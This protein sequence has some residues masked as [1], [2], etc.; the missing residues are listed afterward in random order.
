MHPKRD[1]QYGVFTYQ[2]LK[3]STRS[4]RSF[5]A[6]QIHQDQI[7]PGQFHHVTGHPWHPL[8]YRSLENNK[9]VPWKGEITIFSIS[10]WKFTLEIRL[11]SNRAGS[12]LSVEI[13]ELV[14]PCPWG[15]H[16]IVRV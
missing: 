7:Q 10:D 11:A 12:P 15:V 16:P 14:N 2:G 6:V 4:R 3:E 5:T 13:E 8:S 9:G 1:S